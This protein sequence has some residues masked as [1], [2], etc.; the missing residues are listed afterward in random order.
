MVPRDATGKKADTAKLIE[1]L[2]QSAQQGFAPAQALLAFFYLDGLFGLPRDMTA[3]RDWSDRS[4]KS[5][6][7]DGRALSALLDFQIEGKQF[8]AKL[9]V[10]DPSTIRAM[11]T[12]LHTSFEEAEKSANGGSIVGQFALATFVQSMNLMSKDHRS[13]WVAY[14]YA[15]LASSRGMDDDILL[16]ELRKSL[17]QTDVAKAGTG[18]GAVLEEGLYGLPKDP[19]DAVEWFQHSGQLGNADAQYELGGMYLRGDGVTRDYGQALK[20]FRLAAAQGRGDAENNIGVMYEGGD[21]VEANYT[22][23][24]GWFQKSAS[25]GNG[26]A[27]KNIQALESAIAERH[28]SNSGAFV[29]PA[30]VQPSPMLDSLGEGLGTAFAAEMWNSGGPDAD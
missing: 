19:A 8:R 30:V 2:K 26:L 11:K 22:E 17:S 12:R 7:L 29:N 1:Q 13:D 25:H 24:L 3:A 5:G 9:A 14:M 16:D 23:A 18:V 6:N 10:N 15:L 27:R 21:G 4:A 20:W 28:A